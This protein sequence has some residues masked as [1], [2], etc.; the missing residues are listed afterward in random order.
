MLKKIE[1][2]TEK[3]NKVWKNEKL[4]PKQLP[5]DSLLTTQLGE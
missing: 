1:V 3:K 4:K 2:K 5:S